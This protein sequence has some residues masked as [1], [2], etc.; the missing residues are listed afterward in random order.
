MSS[1]ISLNFKPY[2]AYESVSATYSTAT[3]EKINV[4]LPRQ[5]GKINP[6]VR[7][8]LELEVENAELR[9]LVRDM[10]HWM[11]CKRPCQQCERYRYPE[12]CE[13]E[14]RRHKIEVETATEE[15]RRMLDESGVE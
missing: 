8:I 15:L 9:E 12:G 3:T 4:R 7:R 5:N 2:T 11:P 13:F 14:I 6:L 1:D 10:L